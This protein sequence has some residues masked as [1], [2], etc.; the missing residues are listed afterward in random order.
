MSTG[1]RLVNLS[2][3]FCNEIPVA[4]I[5]GLGEESSVLCMLHERKA[6]RPEIPVYILWPEE[7]Y[8]FNQWGVKG[9]NPSDRKSR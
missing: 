6:A 5:C 7:D 3:Q 4:V 2:A 1:Q 8:I 9:M